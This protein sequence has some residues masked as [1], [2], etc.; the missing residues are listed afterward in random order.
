[1]ATLPS[2]QG[3]AAIQSMI[4]FSNL[5]A[6]SMLPG[7]GEAEGGARAGPVDRDDDIAVLDHGLQ[8]VVPQERI[9]DAALVAHE[10]VSG[11]EP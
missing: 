8:P 9:Q 11:C 1:M 10:P 3:W 2:D 7:V 6:V 4:S 5:A